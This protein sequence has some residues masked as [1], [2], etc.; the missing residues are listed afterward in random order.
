LLW[1]GVKPMPASFLALEA[2]NRRK[3]LLRSFKQPHERLFFK[4]KHQSAL[5]SN[6]R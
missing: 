1:L 5:G 2:T 3:T 6:A 4:K